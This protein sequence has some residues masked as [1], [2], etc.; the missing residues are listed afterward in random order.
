[1]ILLQKFMKV[2]WSHKQISQDTKKNT[3]SVKIFGKSQ[4]NA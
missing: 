1:M 2:V 3:T 4:N